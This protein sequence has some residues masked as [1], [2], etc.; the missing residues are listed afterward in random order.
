[1][2]RAINLETSDGAGEV[3]ARQ[4]RTDGGGDGE[5]EDAGFGVSW[6]AGVEAGEGALNAG[7]ESLARG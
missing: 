7:R 2:P 6:V 1:M 5:V 4:V 3:R